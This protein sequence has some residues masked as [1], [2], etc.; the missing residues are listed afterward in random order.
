MDVAELVSRC[1]A[2]DRQAMHLLYQQ[3][4][5][6]LLQICRQYAKDDDVAKDLLHDAFVI[7]LTSFDKLRSADRLVPWMS[8]IV[9]NVGCHYCKH[10]DKEQTALLEMADEDLAAEETVPLPDYEQLQAFVNQL[11]EGYQQVF[12]LSVFEGLSHQEIAQKL[13]IAPHSSSSQ[14]SHAKR[15]L[16]QLVKQWWMLILLLIAIP[17][18]WR[19]FYKTASE[20]QPMIVASDSHETPLETT[21]ESPHEEP[22]N[23]LPAQQTV[24]KDYPADRLHR[25]ADNTPASEPQD[26]HSSDSLNG[27]SSESRESLLSLP[28]RDVRRTKFNSPKVY[29]PKNDSPKVSRSVTPHAF[30]TPTSLAK[31]RTS[32]ATRLWKLSLSFNGQ[33][34]RSDDFLA[35]TT[36]GQGSFSAYSNQMIPAEQVFSNWK[37]YNQYLNTQ[38]LS[39]EETRSIMSIAAQNV[40]VNGG[41]MEAHYEHQLPATIQ[42]LFTRMLSSRLFI[43]TGLSHTRLTSTI[44]TGSSEAFI[45]ELQRVN[46]IGVPFCLGWQWTDKAGLNLYSSAGVVLE[47]P[48]LCTTDVKHMA[49]GLNTFNK[50]SAP[51][52]PNQWSATLGLGLQYE[53]TPQLGIYME[54]S[55]QYFF[56]NGSNLKTYR[57]EHPIGISLPIGIR[58]QW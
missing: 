50:R 32:P 27:R 30:P 41:V 45:Q 3:Y 10:V 49:N 44:T 12:K 11:P 20:D 29:Q 54:P 28:S 2:G 33:A 58:F 18:A 26:E 48:V 40:A 24:D 23:V 9:R 4:S 53:L 55:L 5:P 56:D 57:T 51:G 43:G 38:V 35:A 17:T 31:V 19:L 13:G 37:D 8:T 46:Y 22:T 52:L 34:G 47:L 1:K 42:F 36:I 21:V 39:D 15:R 14:L 6:R 16:Q 25:L 7:I